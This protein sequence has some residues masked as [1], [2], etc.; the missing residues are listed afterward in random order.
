MAINVMSW[1]WRESQSSG[2]D[3]LV[4]LAIADQAHEDGDGAWPSVRTLA[5]RARV[6]DRTVQRC[7]NSLVLLGEL[8]IRK[9]VGRNGVNV[10]RIIMATECHPVTM[11]EGVTPCPK[12][13]TPVTPGGDTGVTR[14]KSEPSRTERE[15]SPFCAEHQPNGTDAKCRKCGRARLAFEASKDLPTSVTLIHES[16]AKN[17]KSCGGDGWIV[18]RDGQPIGKCPHPD[19]MASAR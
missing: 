5:G 14:T 16:R 9:G 17:C 3:L 19:K 4:L 1:V 7:I 10:Y 8:E 15:R 18:N 11:S 13:V 2:A 6:S 12:G